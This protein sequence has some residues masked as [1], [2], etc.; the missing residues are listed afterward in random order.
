MDNTLCTNTGH[1]NIILHHPYDPNLVLLC[2]IIHKAGC[3]PSHSVQ[4]MI[5]FIYIFFIVSKVKCSILFN[6]KYYF[7]ILRHEVSQR[8]LVKD[9]YQT[10]REKTYS[11]TSTA[12]LPVGLCSQL[13]LSGTSKD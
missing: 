12:E 7:P 1:I 3:L 8:G 4:K 11:G 10:G 5:F 9:G 6:K 13:K 2:F